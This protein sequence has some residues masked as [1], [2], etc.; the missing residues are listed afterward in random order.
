M[1]IFK[2]DKVE[3]KYKNR[4]QQSF[5]LNNTHIEFR[6]DQEVFS[7]GNCYSKLYCILYCLKVVLSQQRHYN[8]CYNTE[9]RE[10]DNVTFYYL[11]DDNNIV[12]ATTKELTKSK[13]NN[14]NNNCNDIA[15][16]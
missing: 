11:D 6:Q 14:D 16:S 15:L 10:F 2:R 1:P 3:G 7:K 5:R 9:T 4:S 13:S 8:F 12:C